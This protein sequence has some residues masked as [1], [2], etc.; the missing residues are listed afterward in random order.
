MHLSEFDFP[1][2]ASLIAAQPIVPRDHARLL[3][4]DR[5]DG[6]MRHLRVADLPTVLRRGDLLVVNDT[7]VIPARV[8]GRKQ[9]G[10]GRAELLFVTEVQ[11]D[12]WEI[13]VKGSCRVGQVIK[14]DQNAYV[15]VIERGSP[16]KV[17]VHSSVSV[18]DLLHEI[19]TMPLP[20]YIQREPMTADQEWYQTMFASEEG[21]VAAPT[22]SLHFTPGLVADLT[23]QGIGLA[24]ITLHVGLATFRPVAVQRIEDHE[25]GAEVCVVSEETVAR[26]QAAQR[27]GG[28]VV[29]VG[30]TTVRALESAAY[31]GAIRSFQ[32][33]T[34][35]FI[36]PGY[37]F[38]VVDALMTN[39]HLPRTTLLMLVAALAGLE[40]LKAAYQATIK[41]RYRFYSYGDAMLIL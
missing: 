27:A 13:L 12:V 28:R 16:C 18:R 33:A 38:R 35:L 25:M 40:Q 1:F 7:K 24:R 32:G 26:V 14:L 34:D 17:R 4:L 10:G 21:A 41:E 20:P 23:A 9:P 22:A 29:A 31:E 2:D 15:E 36:R 19:G 11:T 30:T 39:F 6:S 8:I 37:R 3:V 5:A